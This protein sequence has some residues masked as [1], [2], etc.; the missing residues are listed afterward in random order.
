MFDLIKENL[1]EENLN[2]NNIHKD[3]VQ[4]ETSAC[5]CD[6]AGAIQCTMPVLLSQMSCSCEGRM[7][8]AGTWHMGA[9]HKCQFC[10]S[11]HSFQ[12][13]KKTQVQCQCLIFLSN[14]GCLPRL[15]SLYFQSHCFIILMLVES[16]NLHS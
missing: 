1:N 8:S 15:T 7:E 4:W 5:V 6:Q 16:Y 9:E 14:S 10:L 3:Y 11:T 2:E 13:K 12:I